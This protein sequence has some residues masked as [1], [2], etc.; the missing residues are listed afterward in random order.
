M[1]FEAVI[2]VGGSLGRGAKLKAICQQLAELGQEHNLLV[3]PGGGAFADT[4]RAYDKRYRLDDD[5][6]H[7]MA[8]LAMDQYGHL[9]AD[10]IPA[11]VPTRSLTIAWTVVQTHR[12]P[13]FLPFDLLWQAD[14][15]PHT[16]S[17]TSDSIA[18]WLAQLTNSAM[19]VLLKNVDGLYETTPAQAPAMPPLAEINL[20]Q[21]TTYEGIDAHLPTLL[22]KA[23]LDMWVINGEKPERLAELFTQGRTKGTYFGGQ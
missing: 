5:T 16:W 12:I 2:K 17:V 23:N 19:L 8:I 11:S 18:A 6:A 4:V 15:L 21:L 22:A 1:P 10:Q 13:V 9:L 7:W 14:P 3:V 20:E